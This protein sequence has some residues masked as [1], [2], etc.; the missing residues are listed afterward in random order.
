MHHPWPFLWLVWSAAVV[1]Y[2][3]LS[4]RRSKEKSVVDLSFW[5]VV[6][7][8]L[9]RIV[10]RLLLHRGKIYQFSVLSAGVGAGIA[11][12]VMI[13]ALIKQKLYESTDQSSTKR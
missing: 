2:F 1:V 3:V 13:W 9:I 6:V 12:L 10:V 11:T 7:L 5:V 8:T 4:L